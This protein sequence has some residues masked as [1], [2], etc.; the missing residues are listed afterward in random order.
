M[1]FDQS[2]AKDPTGTWDKGKDLSAVGFTR[3]MTA[4]SNHVEIGLWM[5]KREMVRIPKQKPRYKIQNPPFKIFRLM[6]V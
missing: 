4:H 1:R 3:H 5:A 2:V 6:I